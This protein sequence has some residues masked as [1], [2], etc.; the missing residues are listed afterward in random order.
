V[1]GG[2]H[3]RPG[4]RR[5]QQRERRDLHPA[6]AD[7]VEQ[8]AAV[9]PREVHV[10]DDG[11]DDWVARED[12]QKQLGFVE[13]DAQRPWGGDLAD[14]ARVCAQDERAEREDRGGESAEP[15]TGGFGHELL[16]G[17]VERPYAGRSWLE[18][19]WGVRTP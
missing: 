13:A 16:F 12:S 9:E 2:V 15:D 4:A 19:P 7:L 18:S 17:M 6:G 10:D 14:H 3:E 1:L 8:L 5:A 11:A